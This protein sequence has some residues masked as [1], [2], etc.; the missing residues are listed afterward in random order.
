MIKQMTGK[1]MAG[2]QEIESKWREFDARL[3]AF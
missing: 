1:A 3:A 2:M